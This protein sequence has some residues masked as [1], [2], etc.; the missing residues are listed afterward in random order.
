[1]KYLIPILIV[2]IVAM[3][4]NTQTGH[5]SATGSDTTNALFSESTLPYQTIPFDK[6]KDADFKP[7]FEE[8]MKRH[9]AEIDSIINDTAAPTFQNTLVALEKSG[10]MLNRVNKVFNAL[11]GANTN[12]TLQKIQEELAPKLSAHEDAIYLNP[13]LFHKIDTLYR[14]REKLNLDSESLRLLEVYH[15]DFVMR[16]ANLPDSSK[17]KL[18]KL[19][20]EEATLTTKFSNQLLGAAKTNALIVDTKEELAGLTDAE[21][22]AAATKAKENNH[23]GKYMLSIINTTQ[24]PALQ[25]LTNRNTR[26]K[27]FEA[28]WNRAEKGDSNDTRQNILRIAKIRIEK[29]KLLGFPNYAAWKLQD[30]MAKTP[31]AVTSFLSKIV[32]AATARAKQEAADI[33]AYMVAHND[34]TTLQPWDWEYY[35]EKVRKEK[36]NIDESQIKPYF[37]LD[38]VLENGVFY[39]ANQL[40]GITFKERK[41]L[42]VYQKDVR[43]FEVFDKDSTPMALFYCDYFKR[44]NKSGG[45]WMDNLVD[46]SKLLG[47]KPVIVNVCNFAK[48]V[49][50]Q[51]ALLSFD[52]VTTM[53]H[54]FG[55]ALHG[56]FA[57]QT[58]PTLSGTAVS[59]DFV[60]MPSQF[61]EHWAL[62]SIVLKNY[63]K[64]YQNGQP[65]PQD[66]INKIKEAAIFNQG[67]MFTELLAAANLDM[68]WHLLTPKDS[69]VTDVDAF[70]KQALQKTGVDL[71]Y[72]PPRYRSTYFL[73]IWSNGYSAGYYA[74]TWA[75]MLDDD[76]YAWFKEHGGLNRENGQKFR[77]MIL[78]RGNTE[79]LSKLYRNF[80]GKDPDTKP[81]LEN[82]GLLVKP[83]TAKNTI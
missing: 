49:D 6:I 58:Y 4:C 8:G 12:D 56:L 81:L 34:T 79:E 14:Q 10:S 51:P 77:D 25:S 75:E 18:K 37:V 44:D 19:N 15:A 55:H 41:D 22:Q 42:P 83:V 61:N 29:A 60:E 78:S 74:Y 71:S 65:M 3:S 53:F 59:R 1:M 46:Q 2:I 40:Y 33:K 13:K 28:S 31:Q 23:E 43:V 39:A 50:G 54:E 38:S 5:G 57:S 27:L 80:R 70:E 24:Q 72:V 73:H 17:E 9:M 36:Y 68:Q 48:P 82:R 64:H 7:A 76:A 30:Q 26:Q 35:A 67:Y 20:E 52:D 11:T 47:T 62:D 21:I 45:A 63:A 16:G 69:T 66:L 32:P